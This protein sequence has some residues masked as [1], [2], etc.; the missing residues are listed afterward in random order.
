MKPSNWQRGTAAVLAGGC[1]LCAGGCLERTICVTT[2]PP[3]ALVW[4]NDV[5]VGRTPLETDFTYYGDYDVRVRR[6]GYEPIVTHAKANTPI[7]EMPGIDLLAEAAPVRF[8]NVVRWHWD[9][10][11]VAEASGDRAAAEGAV[12]ARANEMRSRMTGAPAKGPVAP[13]KP[14]ERAG[15]AAP[16]V[17]TADVEANTPASAPDTSAK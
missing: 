15:E 9:L 6:E 16:S 13:E 2:D 5:E 17:G 14:A 8:H 4:I 10:T 11:P 1:V 3:G 12:I 7:Q